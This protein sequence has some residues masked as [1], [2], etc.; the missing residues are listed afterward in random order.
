M[1]GLKSGV[2]RNINLDELRAL[3]TN[4]AKSRPYVINVACGSV[5]IGM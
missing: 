2:T 1:A 5:N 3:F 4:T